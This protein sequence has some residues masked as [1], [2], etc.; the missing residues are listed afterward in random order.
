VS[1]SDPVTATVQ[2]DSGGERATTESPHVLITLIESAIQ[3]LLCNEL[4]CVLTMR[5]DEIHPP[6]RGQE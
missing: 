2:S 5:L 3:S 4:L 6:I 1:E